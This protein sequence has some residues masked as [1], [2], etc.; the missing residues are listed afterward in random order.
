MIYLLI[1]I[2]LLF[3]SI[4]FDILEQKKN[5]ESHW[6][7]AVALLIFLT[8]F[9]WRVGTDTVVYVWEFYNVFPDLLHLQA[10]SFSSI[11]RMPLWVLTNVICKTIWNDFLLLQFVVA[12]VS[13]SIN[14]YFIK[15]TCPSLR[16][17]VLFCYFIGTYVFLHMD[18]LR[19]SLAMSMFLLAILAFNNNKRKLTVWYA[20]LALMFHIYAFIPIL[21]FVLFYFLMPSNKW[22]HFIFL[23]LIFCVTIF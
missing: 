22:V 7:I 18:T 10:S 14:A 23:L 12:F 2:Y 19:E 5:K 3:L 16:F 17:F 13:I 21:L 15:K 6:T 8:G 11:G 4:H 9:R 20:F 1:F